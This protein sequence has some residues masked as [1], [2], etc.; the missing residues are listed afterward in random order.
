[1]HQALPKQLG[2]HAH[3]N[4]LI[5]LPSFILL[6]FLLLPLF[7]TTVMMIVV[8]GLVMPKHALVAVSPATAKSQQDVNSVVTARM[9]V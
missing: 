6:L 9:H 4:I 7:T 1:M 2:V 5:F 8:A 3:A